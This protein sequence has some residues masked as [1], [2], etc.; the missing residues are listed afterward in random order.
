[1]TIP[2][3]IVNNIPVLNEE[4]TWCGFQVLTPA[5]GRAV[6]VTVVSLWPQKWTETTWGR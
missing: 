5:F 1:M 4:T 2:E 6:L 3:L